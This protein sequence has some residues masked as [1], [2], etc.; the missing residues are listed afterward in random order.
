M[1]PDILFPSLH[2]IIPKFPV[3][4]HE[5]KSGLFEHVLA[6]G[7]GHNR[8]GVEGRDI[9]FVKHIKD[10]EFLG[11]RPDAAVFVSVFSG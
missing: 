8:V 4:S 3:F 2:L 7:I 11:L 10:D 1:L 6:A 9:G 5:L